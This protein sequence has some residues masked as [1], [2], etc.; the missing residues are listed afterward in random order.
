VIVSVKSGDANVGQVRDL[1]GV[2]DREKAAMGLFITLEPSTE[3][4]RVE[5]VSAGF[6]HS[7]RWQKDY[8]KIQ[9]L[10]VEELLGGKQPSL[11]PFAARGFAK[12][13]RLSRQ[14]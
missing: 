6:Y 8:A 5:A 10:T 13:P 1:K 12:A 9:I 11:P 7:D 3:P 14:K 2:V 4:M